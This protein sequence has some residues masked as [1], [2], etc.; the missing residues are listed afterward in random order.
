[1]N[2]VINGCTK[3][4]SFSL[5]TKGFFGQPVLLSQKAIG[6]RFKDFNTQL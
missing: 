1:M 5:Y 4:L 3:Y 2:T 6:T